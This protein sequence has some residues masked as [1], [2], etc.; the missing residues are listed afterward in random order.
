MVGGRLAG[1]FWPGWKTA[2]VGEDDIEQVI[3]RLLRER[4]AGKTICP[5]DAAREAGTAD[6]WRGLMDPVRAAAL[7]LVDRGEVEVTQGGEVVDLASATG[8]IRLRLPH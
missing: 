5:S 6:T 3:L 4:G 2:L 7:R 8:P 1:R